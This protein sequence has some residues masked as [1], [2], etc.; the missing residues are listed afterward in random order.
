[1]WPCTTP[2]FYIKWLPVTLDMLLNYI[3]KLYCESGRIRELSS[4]HNRTLYSWTH[5]AR[6]ACTRPNQSAFQHGNG[7]T[8]EPTP[9]W[10]T[11]DS[12]QLLGEGESPTLQWITPHPGR[13]ELQIVNSGPLKIKNKTWTWK[14]GGGGGSGGVG[15]RKGMNGIKMHP[16]TCDCL[17]ERICIF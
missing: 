6:V 1:M 15:G 12:W 5:R 3:L 13:H 11:T 4:E 7:E 16:V 14:M 2:Q 8:G 9:S 17:K 10:G